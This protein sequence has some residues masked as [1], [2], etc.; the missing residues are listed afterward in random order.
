MGPD[1]E[2]PEAILI[3]ELLEEFGGH[4]I[5]HISGGFIQS[6]AI[7]GNSFSTGL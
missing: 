7:T 5:R 4:R 6:I 3:P 1:Q 2:P